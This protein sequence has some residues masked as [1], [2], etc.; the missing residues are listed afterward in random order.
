[1]MSCVQES[2]AATSKTPRAE[3]TKMERTTSDDMGLSPGFSRSTANKEELEMMKSGKRNTGDVE[4]TTLFVTSEYGVMMQ[5]T[6]PLAPPMEALIAC[7]VPRLFFAAEDK[8][9]G[10]LLDHT[11]WVID[12]THTVW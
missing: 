12:W 9:K 11:F 3:E 5:D 7:S 6:F 10:E 1:M 2:G 8:R 4:V